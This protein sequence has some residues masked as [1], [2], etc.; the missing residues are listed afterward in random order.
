MH[1]SKG[2]FD[3]NIYERG[4]SVRTSSPQQRESGAGVRKM[5]NTERRTHETL[6]FVTDKV[7]P[8]YTTNSRSSDGGRSGSGNELALSRRDSRTKR[9]GDGVSSNLHSRVPM[10][11]A[12]LQCTY[13]HT[14]KPARKVPC[15]RMRKSWVNSETTLKGL[16]FSAARLLAGECEPEKLERRSFPCW[17]KVTLRQCYCYSSYFAFQTSFPSVIQLGSTNSCSNIN[18]FASTVIRE[19]RQDF[20]E[21]EKEK[22]I[23]EKL[24]TRKFRIMLLNPL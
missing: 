19:W 7:K 12:Y 1:R 13:A 6:Q 24:E 10:Y 16:L 9:L 4:D 14:Q 22:F 23:V 17:K 8:I 3:G 20:K 21:I 2:N 11:P 5:R 18:S 15:K